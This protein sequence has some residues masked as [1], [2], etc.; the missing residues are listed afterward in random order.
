[1]RQRQQQSAAPPGTPFAG[2]A[3]SPPQEALAASSPEVLAAPSL[4]G[5]ES[6]STAV[7]ATEPPAEPQTAS[8]ARNLP[9]GLLSSRPGSCSL[10]AK[11]VGPAASCGDWRGR[12]LAHEHAI[13]GPAQLFVRP[14]DELLAALPEPDSVLMPCRQH[15]YCCVGALL[16]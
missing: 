7:I 4:G 1:M 14:A 15:A 10:C 3:L 9:C 13:V 8:Q 6:G 11:W 16:V 2:P 12:R 5:A